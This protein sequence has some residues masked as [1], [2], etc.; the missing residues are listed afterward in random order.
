MKRP[1]YTKVYL[2]K[3]STVICQAVHVKF[4]EL[5]LLQVRRQ[6]LKSGRIN[7]NE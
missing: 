3:F 1:V 5:T 6:R 7:V 4:L 2:K